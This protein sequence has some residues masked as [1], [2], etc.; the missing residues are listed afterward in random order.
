[1]IAPTSV[2]TSVDEAAQLLTAAADPIRL[3]I[4]RRLAA[5]GRTC[6]C[7]LTVEADVAA[8]LLSYHL[9]VLREAGLIE[10]H[11]RGRWIDYQLTSVALSR[12]H[13]ALPNSVYAAPF[14]PQLP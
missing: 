13:G 5:N 7:D 4:L 3:R 11:R 1:M 9:K 8:N 6:V 10:G 2:E 12:L 14:M